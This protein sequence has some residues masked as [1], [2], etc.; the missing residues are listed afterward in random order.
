MDFCPLNRLFS[1]ACCCCCWLLN[2]KDT[3]NVRGRTTHSE[4]AANWLL[5]GTMWKWKWNGV[6]RIVRADWEN[7]KKW[8]MRMKALL[9]RCRINHQSSSCSALISF[10]F[11]VLQFAACSVPF[12]RRSIWFVLT[13]SHAKANKEINYERL[14]PAILPI[15]N[16][17]I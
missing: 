9:S 16:M 15:I 1:S 14:A 6:F 13:F 5:C 17:I 3:H 11:V 8:K 10:Y 2:V 12:A 4:H 7:K